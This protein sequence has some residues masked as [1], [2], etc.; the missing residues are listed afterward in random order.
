MKLHREGYLIIAIATVIIGVLELGNFYLLKSL[1]W[2]WLFALI[3]LILLVFYYLVIQF[4]RVPNI[5]P[6]FG[7]ND[8]L[9]PADGKVVVIEETEENEYFKDRRIQVSIFMSPL[10]VH[11]NFNPISGL[12]K[13]VKY[14][15]GLFL[16]AW[17]PKSSTDN[18][19]S[20]VVTEHK[21]GKE[22]LFRQ[23][24]GAVA[25]RICYYV[26]PGQKVET[27]SEYGFIKFGSR[28]DLFLPLDTKINVKIGDVVKGRITKIGE[29]SN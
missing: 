20:T 12:I 14:H 11:A 10:N 5:T 7:E 25:R 8:I 13:Y 28:I 22:V 2:T 6:V 3:S 27:G 21:S 15:K 19:R 1:G 4:F 26:E 18:E 24:A 16:V 29:L 17:H 23:I 9:C